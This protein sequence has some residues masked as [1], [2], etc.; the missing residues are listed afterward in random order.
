MFKWFFNRQENKKKE[1]AHNEKYF[2]DTRYGKT[3]KI[4]FGIDYGKGYSTVSYVFYI[5]GQVIDEK[6]PMFKSLKDEF[7]TTMKD[8]DKTMDSMDATM[9]SMG[10]LFNSSGLSMKDFRGPKNDS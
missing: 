8:F 2:K 5:N 4:N 1:K 3:S 9:Q 7:D 10:K 6:N